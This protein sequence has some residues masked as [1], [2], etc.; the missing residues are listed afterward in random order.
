M[1]DNVINVHVNINWTYVPNMVVSCYN[2]VSPV[3]L[4]IVTDVVDVVTV[5]CCVTLSINTLLN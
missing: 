2:I 4:N 3:A 5:V 1:D